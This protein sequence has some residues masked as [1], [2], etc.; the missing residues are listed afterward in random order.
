V[1]TILRLAAGTWL[2]LVA[3]PGPGGFRQPPRQALSAAGPAHT[4]RPLPRARPV[5]VWLQ[6]NAVQCRPGL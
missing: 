5:A 6:F 1:L 4:P 3:A 2:C